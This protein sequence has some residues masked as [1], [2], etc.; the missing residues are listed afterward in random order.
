MV[1]IG[2]AVAEIGGVKGSH[3]PLPGVCRAEPFRHELD[4][5]TKRPPNGSWKASN[6]MAV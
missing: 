5:H 4:F 1:L 2:M 3:E 6:P